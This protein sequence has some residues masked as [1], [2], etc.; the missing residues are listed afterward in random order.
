MPT[1]NITV[2][3][4]LAEMVHGKVQSGMYG[5]A[6]EVVREALRLMHQRDQSQQ[7]SIGHVQEKLSRGLRQAENGEFSEQ[8]VGEII[9][10]AKAQ[11]QG[12]DA[13]V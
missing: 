7:D 5:D 3:D 8:S 6:S 2:T 10:E 11:K 12:N 1:I 9:A 13:A 4:E